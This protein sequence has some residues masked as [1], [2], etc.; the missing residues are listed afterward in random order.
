MSG[1]PEATETIAALAAEGYKGSQVS[2]SD[3]STWVSVTWLTVPEVDSPQAAGA[4]AQTVLRVD[5]GARR[6]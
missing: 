6:I 3:G 4:I 1:E 5:P 2:F